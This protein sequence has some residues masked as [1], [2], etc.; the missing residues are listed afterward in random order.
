MLLM[1]D[2]FKS[3]KDSSFAID[4]NLSMSGQVFG[5]LVLKTEALVVECA[6][7]G[8]VVATNALL[9]GLSTD[10]SLLK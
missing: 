7:R 5:A 2:L 10:D 3:I 9:A 4:N 6:N 1:F 8:R